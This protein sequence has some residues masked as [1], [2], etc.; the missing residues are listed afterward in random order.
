MNRGVTTLETLVGE[1]VSNAMFYS[2]WVD[3]ERCRCGSFAWDNSCHSGMIMIV[4][5]S[6][7]EQMHCTTSRPTSPPTTTWRPSSFP[8]ISP[9]PTVSSDPS[10]LPTQYPIYEPSAAVS[11][12]PFLLSCMLLS[13][14]LQFLFK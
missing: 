5:V 6:G 11:K 1:E 3:A 9:V 14:F 13:S 4:P 12:N 10:S 8:T 2:S 7:D